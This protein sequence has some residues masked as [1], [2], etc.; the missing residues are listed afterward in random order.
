M[1]SSLTRKVT[2]SAVVCLL[3]L[4]AVASFTIYGMITS[5]D[6]ANHVTNYSLKQLELSKQFDRALASAIAKAQML[7]FTLAEQDRREVLQS[8]ELAKLHLMAI[9]KL[10]IDEQLT[11]H[12]HDEH[13]Q[14]IQLLERR[15][16]L[17]TL[18]ERKVAALL[19]AVDAY[20]TPAVI[21]ALD[22][23]RH[24]ERTFEQMANDAD[25]IID[26]EVT[27][28]TQR[29]QKLNRVRLLMAPST[30]GVLVLMAVAALI[31]LRRGV[32]RPINGLSAAAS[33]VAR[34]DLSPVV[35]I[36]SADEIG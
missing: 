6:S 36:T 3:V 21:E 7:S 10:E 30:F 32:V 29:M 5:I 33:A 34:G 18:T 24:F 2:V 9:E 12:T 11:H 27:A 35:P 23:L 25:V 14:L 16:T 4:V 31:L 1:R 26:R 8:L 20:D 19:D 22:D 17:L 28:S 15:R 13:P